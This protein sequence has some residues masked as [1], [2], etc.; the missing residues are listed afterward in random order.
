MQVATQSRVARYCFEGLPSFKRE[1]IALWNWYSRVAIGS[2]DWKEWLTDIVAHVV[3][4]PEGLHLR[5]LQTHAVDAQFGEKVLDFGSK[6]ELSIGRDADNDVV[7]PAQAVSS[8]NT[9]L[10]FKDGQLFVEDL[11]DSVGTYVWEKKIEPK[12]IRPLVNGD[13]FTVFPYRFRV[14]L[15]QSWSA[16]TTV[17]ISNGRVQPQSYA[18]FSRNSLAGW[19]RFTISAQPNAG[20]VLVEVSQSFLADLQTR[21]LAP[22]GIRSANRLTPSDDII[23]QLI[24]LAALERV[25][26]RLKFPVQFSLRSAKH[27]GFPDSLR[28]M[29][30][31]AAVGIGDLTG[32]VRVFLPFEFLAKCRPD[33]LAAP[34]GKHPQG[35]CWALPIS[36]G[37]IDL[38][39]AEMAQVEA[40]DVVMTQNAP[41]ALF[42]SD[43]RRY[44]VMSQLESNFTRFRID[45]YVERSFSVETGEA[46]ATASKPDLATLPLRLHVVVGEKEFTL[47]E[48]ESLNSGAI[49]ELES[50]KTDPVR[51]MVNGK[52]L[53]EGELVEVE[54][55]LAVR[56]LRWR[57]S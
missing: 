21:V 44:W 38:T 39:P 47:A 40:G 11:G 42:P 27:A 35:L 33:R 51:L 50:A 19:R 48:I 7:V 31:Q 2:S 4:R 30:L 45:K 5:L 26:R 17:A 22:A 18:E 28:G 54:G 6:Q 13:R 37:S 14:L 57:D 53:G 49:V 46:T 8:K 32:Q 15:E 34:A 52:I 56:V 36:I 25:N 10:F 9:R 29:S 55:A 20:D 43:F 16:E 23:V 41:A 1:E 12:Q 3:E 24:M